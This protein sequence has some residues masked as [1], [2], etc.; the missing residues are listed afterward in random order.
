MK[1]IEF[2]R[3]Q[4]ESKRKRILK[5]KEDEDEYRKKVFLIDI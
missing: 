1:L 5:E 4:I 2:Y 3:T